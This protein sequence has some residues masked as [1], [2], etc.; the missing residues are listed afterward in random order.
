MVGMCGVVLDSMVF[1]ESFYY[2]GFVVGVF[3]V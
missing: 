3:F 1:Y 2:C